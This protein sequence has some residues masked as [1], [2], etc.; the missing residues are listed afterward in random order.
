MAAIRTRRRTGSS[1]HANATN[2]KSAHARAAKPPTATPMV[3]RMAAL[4]VSVVVPCYNEVDV[5][6]HTHARLTETL[7]RL[8]YGYELLY[9]ND[10]SSDGTLDQ[11][12]AIQAGDPC[13]RVISLSRNFGHQVAISAGVEAASG[14][15]VV[16]ID[17]DLQDPPELIAAMLSK[18]RQGYQVVYG[19]REER[20][21]ETRFKLLTAKWFY[22]TLNALSDVEIPP[23]VGDFRLLDRRVV[24]ALERMPERNRFVRGMVSWVGFRQ[25]AIPYRREPRIAGH[26][27]YPFKRMLRLAADGILSFSVVPLRLA[28]W[29]GLLTTALAAVG[30]AYAVILRLFTSEWVAGYTLLFVSILLIG[31]VQMLLL[32]IL[33][34]YVG[35]IFTESKNR[36]LYF[37]SEY[38]GF[39][40]DTGKRGK[41]EH[42]V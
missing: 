26:T 18:W 13:V 22:R 41:R 31:G 37:V 6:P 42:A 2:P 17:A 35:R 27:K 36:P 32:G 28:V 9:V 1:P 23:S 4:R 21:G 39:A 30:I 15:A 7:A 8:P 19:K 3:P 11:L 20:E 25:C 10:G 34:E 24:E 29:L 14:D 5:I 33:G 12:R 16:I 40:A 38:I